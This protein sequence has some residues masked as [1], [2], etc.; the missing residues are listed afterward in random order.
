MKDL[1]KRSIVIIIFLVFLVYL[2]YLA[3]QGQTITTG[4]YANLNIPLFV[5]LIALCVYLTAFYGIYP[6]HIKFSR[7]ALLV[8]GLA[9]IVISQTML[10]ND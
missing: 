9:L 8:V 7:T 6:L 3:I 4:E 1:I 10:V 5:I 2:L